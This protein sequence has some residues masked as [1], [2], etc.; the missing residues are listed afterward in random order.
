LSNS[1]LPA[2]SADGRGRGR[3]EVWREAEGVARAERAHHDAEYHLHDCGSFRGSDASDAEKARL[4]VVQ[5]CAY[6]A[7]IAA[8]EILGEK[9]LGWGLAKPSKFELAHTTSNRK[10]PSRCARYFSLQIFAQAAV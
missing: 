10:R 3:R 7:G 6:F 8:G 5:L 9:S 4:K 1:V 2:N